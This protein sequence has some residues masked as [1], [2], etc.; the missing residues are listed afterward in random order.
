MS[1]GVLGELYPICVA[2]SICQCFKDGYLA[3]TKMVS[4]K[5][6]L[7][8][9]A[10]LPTILNV[11]ICVLTCDVKMVINCG[12]VLEIFLEPLSKCSCRFSNMFIITLHTGT[13]VYIYH[14]ISQYD[15]V[16]I[17]HS[18]QK[19]LNGSA[20]C[21]VYLYPMLVTNVLYTVTEP[22]SVR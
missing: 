18:H 3:H 2:G 8:F 1:Y 4:F 16:S 15:G 20:S 13:L 19:V 6:L 22:F 7:R 12:R 5:V 14:S 10:S 21:E 9:W 11:N 17:L